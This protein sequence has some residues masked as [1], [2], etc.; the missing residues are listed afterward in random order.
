MSDQKLITI[1]TMLA[2]HEAQIEAMNDMI[3]KQWKEIDVLKKRLDRATDKIAE[4]NAAADG[5]KE[6]GEL[7]VTEIAARDKPPHY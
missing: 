1:E 3:V 6:D 5:G 4:L 2:H 7:S